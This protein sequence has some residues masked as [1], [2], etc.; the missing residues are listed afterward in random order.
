M[1]RNYAYCLSFGNGKN[2]KKTT[3]MNTTFVAVV[4]NVATQ[5]KKLRHPGFG[6]ICNEK[7][8]G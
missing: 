5:E 8:L 6:N 1:T 4:L 2:E 3:M 7:K